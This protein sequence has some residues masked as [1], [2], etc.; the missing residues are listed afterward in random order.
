MGSGHIHHMPEGRVAL[1]HTG[2][3][4]GQLWSPLWF[5]KQSIRAGF[6]VVSGSI[7]PIQGKEVTLSELKVSGEE[8]SQSWGRFQNRCACMCSWPANREAFLYLQLRKLLHFL[9]LRQEGKRSFF[10]LQTFVSNENYDSLNA[11]DM[12]LNM[13][14]LLTCFD[15]LSIKQTLTIWHPLVIHS[16]NATCAS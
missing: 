4:G 9:M 8:E 13:F 5:G 6:W 3:T 7:C 10:A 14:E 2:E 11:I 15:S 1:D 16:P 12:Q